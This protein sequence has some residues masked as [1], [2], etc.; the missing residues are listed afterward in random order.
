MPIGAK[1]DYGSKEVIKSGF[2]GPLD[3]AHPRVAWWAPITADVHV[4]FLAVNGQ[5][6]GVVAVNLV[7]AC[8][9]RVARVALHVVEVIHVV[10]KNWVPHPVEDICDRY[11]VNIREVAEVLQK[12][13]NIIQ[14]IINKSHGFA[15]EL[16]FSKKLHFKKVEI[17]QCS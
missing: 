16:F 14:W 6:L 5:I 17:E 3:I 2:F 7:L 8:G 12:P 9:W 4:D 11:D 13:A 15:A 10:Y 1:W